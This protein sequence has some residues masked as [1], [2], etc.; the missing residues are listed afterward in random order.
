MQPIPIS[1]EGCKGYV[2]KTVCAVMRDGTEVVGTIRGVNDR[3]LE[4]EFANPSAYILSAKGKKGKKS[5]KSTKGGAHTSAFG[6]YGY[7]GYGWGANVLAWE[8]I[9]LLFLIPFLFI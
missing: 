8:A 1:A 9:A 4:L 5:S 6:P 7:G 2:G 3:G